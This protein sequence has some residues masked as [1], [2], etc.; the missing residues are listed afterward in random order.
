VS[1]D[2]LEFD[3]RNPIIMDPASAIKLAL[4]SLVA[5]PIETLRQKSGLT[6]SRPLDHKLRFKESIGSTRE[7]DRIAMT[8]RDLSLAKTS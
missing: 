4:L 3:R 7:L 8:K 6:A 5:M 1:S 2:Q